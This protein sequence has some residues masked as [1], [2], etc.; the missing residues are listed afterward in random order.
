MCLKDCIAMTIIAR[1]RWLFGA[2]QK[3]QDESS[4]SLCCDHCRGKLRYSS[5]RYWR[6]RFCSAACVSAYQQRLS[7]QAQQKIY[8]IDG[9]CPAWKA[10]S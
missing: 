3:V 2:A 6:M 5:H 8:E 9:H 10:A 4:S 1:P 7:M